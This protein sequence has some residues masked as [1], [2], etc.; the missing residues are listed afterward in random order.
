MF[1]G[2]TTDFRTRT[3]PPGAAQHQLALHLICGG[4]NAAACELWVDVEEMSATSYSRRTVWSLPDT[5]KAIGATALQSSS[6]AHKTIDLPASDKYS[7]VIIVA[8]WSTLSG[9]G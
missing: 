7:Q 3:F 5:D 8:D 6:W 1:G 9:R 4:D 2:V